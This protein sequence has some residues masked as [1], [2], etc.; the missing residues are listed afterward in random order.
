HDP[1]PLGPKNDVVADD[2]RGVELD[3]E[4]VADLVWRGGDPSDEVARHQQVRDHAPL[5]VVAAEIHPGRPGA[6]DHV[7]SD[8]EPLHAH[9]IG[10]DRD[11]TDLNEPAVLDHEAVT[12]H[13][14]DRIHVWPGRAELDPPDH[15]MTGPD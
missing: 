10:R 8:G 6:L 15:E 4:A 9:V 11:A 5:P 2:S 7:A 14:P 13:D 12:E 3:L 1:G